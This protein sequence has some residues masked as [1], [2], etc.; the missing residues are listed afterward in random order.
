MVVTDGVQDLAEFRRVVGEIFKERSGIERPE[1]VIGNLEEFADAFFDRRWRRDDDELTVKS[2]VSR[3]L[4]GGRLLRSWM[5]F[6]F[7]RISSSS[8]KSRAA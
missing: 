3:N 8:R 5:S 2:P 1:I 7:A 4:D 6:R